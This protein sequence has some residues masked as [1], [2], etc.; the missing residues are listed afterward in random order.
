MM[1]SHLGVSR[2]GYY[3]WRK[4]SPSQREIDDAFLVDEI[5]RS[6]RESYES[7]GSPRVWR[8]LKQQGI[9]VGR[10]R[11]ERLMQ[12][13]QIQSKSVVLYPKRNRQ[14]LLFNSVENCSRKMT[15][16][17]PDQLWV[18]DITYLKVAGV[19]WYLAVVMDR[20][21]RRILGL[22][23]GKNKSASLVV[24]ALKRALKQRAVQPGLVFHSDRGSEYLAESHRRVLD[25]AGIKQSANRANT[26]TDNAHMES[27][28][29][30]YKSDAYHG[31]VFESVKELKATL[32]WYE[33]FYN[34]QRL[35]S[36]LNYQSPA[37]FERVHAN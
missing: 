5:R 17:G 15:V 26:M 31:R 1:C 23:L 37:E 8:D 33:R 25:G 13:N 14:D 19:M 35:H 28:N 21:T 29:K 10:G 16:T 11:I 27:W 7:Y 24:T 22:A 9:E 6:H 30:S 2:S 32:R 12:E 4:R 20:Y 34:E 3:R 18:G 36:A